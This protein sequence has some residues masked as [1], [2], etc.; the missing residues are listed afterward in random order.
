VHKYFAKTHFLGK[1]VKYL[2]ECHSTNQELLNLSKNES[3][4]EG[5]VLI[6]DYQKS[7][8]G[9]RGNE[10]ESEQSKNA[11]FS[12]YI[13]PSFIDIKQQ[14]LLTYLASLAVRE[15]LSLFSKNENIK[16]KW[17]ND[18][19]AEGRK[20]CGIL[21]ECNLQG[22]IIQSAIVGVGINVNQQKFKN[23]YATSLY[24]ISNLNFS[25]FE[26]IESFILNFEKYYLRLKSGNT[27]QIIEEYQNRMLWINET[28]KFKT[29]DGNIIEGEIKG[30][31]E[32]GLLLVKYKSKIESF[33]FK[34]IEYL[35]DV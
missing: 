30:V 16:I 8:R 3:I 24:N 18:V 22:A 32:I 6:T 1:K 12:M 15:S 29:S 9:Q 4:P 7:G 13:K 23:K 34:E 2:T 5:T 20:I 14:F 10:W 27:N 19:Y 33:N 25:V 11:L 26:V 31:N 17:P 28:K 21:T 35:L